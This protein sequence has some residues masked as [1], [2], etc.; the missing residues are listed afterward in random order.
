[1]KCPVCGTW[2]VVKESRGIRRRRECAN[3]HKFT[4]EEVVVPPDVLKQRSLANLFQ[5]RNNDDSCS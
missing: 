1:M 3:E 2:T 5:N 4:T